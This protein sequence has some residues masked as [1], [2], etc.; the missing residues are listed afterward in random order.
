MKLEIIWDIQA[1]EE[2][3]NIVKYYRE[4]STG[5]IAQNIKKAILQATREIK[6]AEQYQI[7]DFNPA[8]RRIIVKNYK[9]LY[10]QHKDNIVI[11][12]A[13]FD[14]RQSTEKLADL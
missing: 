14:T 9:I 10:R 7:D 11:I 1:K 4:N 13:I 8:Y 3:K 5:K 12:I 2:L 6:F